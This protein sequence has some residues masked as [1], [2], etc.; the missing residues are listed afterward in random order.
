M[1][2]LLQRGEYLPGDEMENDNMGNRG[3]T[4]SQSVFNELKYRWVVEVH[5]CC[6]RWRTLGVDD[7]DFDKVVVYTRL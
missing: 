5:V 1:I 7:A 4:T 3:K 6:F 2:L